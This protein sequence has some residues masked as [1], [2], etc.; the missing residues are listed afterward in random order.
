MH[1]HHVGPLLWP[2]DSEI[3]ELT[4]NHQWRHVRSTDNPSD[5]LSRGINPSD[6]HSCQLWWYG[7]K[8]LLDLN[9][10]FDDNQ[11]E[12]SIDAIPEQ[13]RVTHTLIRLDDDP[14]FLNFSNFSRL[15]RSIAY[16]LRFTNN[17]KSNSVKLNGP[18][19]VIEL[20]HSLII[21]IKCLQSRK[22]AHEISQL[23]SKKNILNSSIL[24]L[25]PFLDKNGILR[26]GGR[27]VNSDISFDQK[28]PILLPSK[29]H[30]VQLLLRQE[31]IKLHHAGAQATL[32]NIRLRFWPINALREIKHIIKQCTICHRFKA[33]ASQ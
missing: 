5:Y 31:H 33:A 10:E 20:E 23:K 30:T 1:L 11:T 32:A 12:K 8:S 27:L 25:N 15:Q 16:C 24:S 26:V 3:Q 18:L 2:I 4:T 21:I 19:A 9:L 29:T 6:I 14:I 22:F 28:H 17:A 13:R 7:P